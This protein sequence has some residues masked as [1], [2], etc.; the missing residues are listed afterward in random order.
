MTTLYVA[1]YAEIRTASSANCDKLH[2]GKSSPR[3]N[4]P[5]ARRTKTGPKEQKNGSELPTSHTFV[6]VMSAVTTY[7]IEALKNKVVSY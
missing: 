1:L 2:D 4:L 7:R 6:D 3:K 5:E